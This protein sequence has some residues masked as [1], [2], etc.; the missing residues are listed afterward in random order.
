MLQL[1]LNNV[2]EDL[3][4]CVRVG[5]E[6]T[7]GLNRVVVHDPERPEAHMIPI[8]V[9]GE[10]KREAGLKPAMVGPAA[11]FGR[12]FRN[13]ACSI[14]CHAG[15]ILPFRSSGKYHDSSP[16]R[17]WIG[18]RKNTFV[19]LCTFVCTF[20]YVWVCPFPL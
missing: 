11:F 7:A 5:R 10:R 6:S 19:H 9:V 3:H 2:R 16:R 17:R 13:R 4:L 15:T 12:T 8:D 14:L 1:P 18:W 20:G